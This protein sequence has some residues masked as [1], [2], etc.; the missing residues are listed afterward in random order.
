[1]FLPYCAFFLSF[2]F[3]L[4]VL[5]YDLEFYGLDKLFRQTGSKAREVN[6]I[7][8]YL[9]QLKLPRLKGGR[10]KSII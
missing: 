10:G 7:G 9:E 1:L 4:V 6:L 8:H 5:G 3:L 2:T